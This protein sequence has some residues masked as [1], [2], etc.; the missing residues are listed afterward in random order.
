MTTF[1]IGKLVHAEARRRAIQAVLNAPE[2]YT[3]KIEEPK[4]NLDQNAALWPRLTLISKAKPD[5]RVQTPEQW[6]AIMMRASGVC[7]VQYLN[8]LDGEPF[9]IGYR[10]SK[11]KKPVFSEL[12]EY[13]DWFIVDNGI[14]DERKM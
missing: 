6:K 2:G 11:L 8:D 9:P 10:S 7:Q 13:I 3:V 1:H 4:R 5:G 12:L 14:E